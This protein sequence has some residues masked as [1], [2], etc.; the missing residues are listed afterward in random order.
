M[1]K[2]TINIGTVANDGT[3]DPLRTAFNKTNQNFTELYD[4][5]ANTQHTHIELTERYEPTGNIITFVR[6]ANTNISDVIDTGLSL[7]RANNGQGIYNSAIEAN[8]NAS[9]SPA[10]TKWNWTG[11]DNLDNVKNRDYRTWREAL[12]KKVGSN[13]VGAELVMHHIPTDKYYK[14]Q[15]TN[16]DIGGVGGANGAFTYTRELIDT[17]DNVGIIFEDGTNQ[18]TASNPKDWPI[19]WLDND[20]YTLRLI[21]ANKTLRGYD[22][23]IFVPRDSDVNFP[24]GTEIQIFTESIGVTVERVQ[25]IEEVEAEIYGVGFGEARASWEI[26]AHSFARMVKVDT[27]LWYLVIP[28]SVGAEA[29]I[30]GNIFVASACSAINFVA[31][32]SGDGAGASTIEIVPDSNLTSTDQYIVIDPTEGGHIHI[33]AGGTQDSSQSL[34]YLGGERTYVR[35]IDNTGVRIQSERDDETNISYYN[36]FNY[37]SGTW[38]EF[39]GNYYVQFTTS[40]VGMQG[41]AFDFS[42]NPLNE[43]IVYYSGSIESNTL[44]YGGS[45]SSLGGNVYRIRVNETPVAN[46]T[47]IDEIHFRIF[48]VKTNYIRLDNND[49]QVEAED[50]VRIYAHDRFAFYNYSPDESIEIFTDYDDQ[51][52]RWAFNHFGGLE[53]PQ[54]GILRVDDQVPTSSIGS[55]DDRQGTLAFSNTHIYFCTA[56]HDGT[57]NVWKRL[58][59]SG[60]TW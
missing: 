35:V 23:T 9:V 47:S 41:Y 12:R 53:F 56:N 15:F 6:P 24:V 18:I 1:A 14:I 5:V 2:Q 25:H 17:T 26:P 27:N 16:W 33:R 4:E 50:D 45:V 38:Y 8:Y 31:N 7:A 59:W 57:T 32:S 34:L 46:N 3:G 36:S 39:E 19:V 44:T 43:M 40:D 29:T 30:T 11:W 20:N 49:F 28:T 48:S 52:Y 37:T 51:E 42:N 54:G 13:I 22:M 60:D 58:A 55:S 10:N 21:D